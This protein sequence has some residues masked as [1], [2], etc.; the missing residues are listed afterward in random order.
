LYAVLA[1]S[2]FTSRIDR[3]PM[4]RFAELLLATVLWVDLAAA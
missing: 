3:E 2:S 4:A 1:V